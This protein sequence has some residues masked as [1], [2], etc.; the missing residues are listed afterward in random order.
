MATGCVK[1][2]SARSAPETQGHFLKQ[3]HSLAS[4]TVAM[5]EKR[6]SQA[7]IQDSTRARSPSLAFA[8]ACSRLGLVFL[9]AALP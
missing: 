8:C 3:L 5:Q 6:G 1:L 7:N 9:I 2:E 4:M